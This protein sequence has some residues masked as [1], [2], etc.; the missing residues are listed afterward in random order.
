MSLRGIESTK[1]AFPSSTKHFKF[2]FNWMPPITR[3]KCISP[4]INKGTN[5]RRS[6]DGSSKP[7]PGAETSVAV[8]D[9]RDISNIVTTIG[10]GEIIAETKE[11]MDMIY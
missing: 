9:H 6:S 4:S 11:E 2:Q 8:T 7:I 10:Q 3:R 1:E 5:S